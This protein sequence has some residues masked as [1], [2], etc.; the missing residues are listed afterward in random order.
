MTLLLRRFVSLVFSLFLLA[1]SSEAAK[2]IYLEDLLDD[3]PIQARVRHTTV[4]VLPPSE[5]ILDYV[6]GDTTT[7]AVTGSA[8]VAYLKPGEKA[9]TTNIVLV[10]QSGNIYSFKVSESDDAEPDLVVYIDYA[11]AIIE[12]EAPGSTK[13]VL[14]EPKYVSRMDVAVYQ[15]AARQAEENARAAWKRAEQQMQSAIDRFRSTYP[16]LIRFEYRLDK[17]ASN[18]PFE[19][20]GMWHDGRFT[21]VRSHA[22]EA[23]AL[24]ENRD[25]KPSLVN[26]D[27]QPDGLYIINRVVDDGHFQIGKHRAK[28]WRERQQSQPDPQIVRGRISLVS[29]KA[30]VTPESTAAPESTATPKVTDETAQSSTELDQ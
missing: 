13:P 29:P 16:T 11:G 28:W 25:G 9:A 5:N 6:A 10:C 30:T 4:I 23:P 3:I 15:E 22:A 26:Y 18:P 2:R 1:A 14:H 21:Y 19:I 24:Y 20:A 8:N 27:L 12:D 7:W 17:K